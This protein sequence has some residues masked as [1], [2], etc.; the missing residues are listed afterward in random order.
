M[1]AIDVEVSIQTHK[2]EAS[3]QLAHRIISTCTGFFNGVHKNRRIDLQGRPI[4]IYG[5]NELEGTELEGY[6]AAICRRTKQIGAQVTEEIYLIHALGG[7][8]IERVS[9]KQKVYVEKT[10]A[11][12]WR[13]APLSE[14]RREAEASELNNLYNDL[15][16]SKP[17]L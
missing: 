1:K 8:R 10:G 2:E 16:Q 15:I 9:E 17:Q 12:E 6:G 14:N 3:G 11:Y 4:V 5:I 13:L 7:V